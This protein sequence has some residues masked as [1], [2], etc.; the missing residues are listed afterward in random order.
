MIARTLVGF[1]AWLLY[2]TAAL[3]QAGDSVVMQARDLFETG[4]SP[5]AVAMLRPLADTSPAAATLLGRIAWQSGN[6]KEAARWLDVAIARDPQR[7]E[8]YVWRARTYVQEI[9]TVSFIRKGTIAGRARSLLDKAVSID[10]ASITAR[11]ARMEY[12]LNAPRIAGGGMDKAR[13][14]AAAAKRVSPY[15]GSLLVGRVEEQAGNVAAAEAEYVA[16]MA[17]YPDSGGGREALSSL[18]QNRARWDDAFRIIDDRLRTNPDDLGML[19][20]LGRA[21]ALSGQRLEAAKRWG[22]PPEVT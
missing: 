6:Y 3:A 11:E 14:E 15:R 21:A 20:Q 22:L 8:A 9:E 1:V 4:N 7:V 16:L 17:S 13:S 10:P 19:Y 5:A 2:A 18:Y 12:Y